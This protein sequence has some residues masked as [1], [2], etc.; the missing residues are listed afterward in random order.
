MPLFVKSRLLLVFT[1]IVTAAMLSACGISLAEDITP[2][3][4]YQ[5]PTASTPQPVDVSTV[6]PLVPPDPAQGAAIYAEK[7]LPCHGETG[8]GDGPQASKLSNP[9]APIGSTELA[10]QRKPAEWF[11]IVTV[12]NLE[13]FMPGFSQSLSD[14]QRWDIVAYVYTL[15]ASADELAQGKEL[16]NTNCAECHGETGLG[17]GAKAASLSTAPTS[18]KEQSELSQLSTNEISDV[19][20]QGAGDMPGFADKLDESQRQAVAAYIRALSFVGQDDNQ[21]ANASATETSATPQATETSDLKKITITGKITNASAGGSVPSNMKVTLVAYQGM[22]PAFELSGEATA[23][24]TYTFSEVEYQADYVYITRV[25]I[26]QMSFNSDILHGSDVTTEQAEL[27]VQIYDV[28]TDAS[29]LRADRLHVFFDFSQPGAVQ[30]VQLYIITNPTE[31]VIAAASPESPVIRFD[32][33]EGAQSLQFEDGTIG[34]RYVETA[35]GFGDTLSVMP[36]QG[37]HQILYAYE[38]PYD[39]KLDLK[40]KAPLPVD[41][42]IIMVPQDGI[43]LKSDQLEDSGE[44]SVQGMSFQMYTNSAALAAG[45]ELSLSL[46]GRANV[47]GGATNENEWLPVA[48]AGAVFLLV[49]AGAA[50]WFLSQR[51]RLKPVME[52]VTVMDVEEEEPLSSDELLDAIVALDDQFQA[53]KLSDTA[54][55]ERRAE[56]KVRLSQ[57]MDQ[58]KNQ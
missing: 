39:R 46:S 29:V 35:T 38:L 40:L 37:Q 12:G 27:P 58:E 32:L 2:P 48:I 47:T 26:D 23:D 50:Y 9:P 43:R 56:L 28:S 33:P 41:A 14:R 53:G 19:I 30:V 21:Q 54:Y 34:D 25:D 44:R 8:M 45:D 49:V 31:K 22:D 13:K 20:A 36:G 11:N 52:G 18:W 57:A 42:A 51:S 4:N 24:G 6:Y 17:D 7:C 15:S 1:V 55:Q 16:Y 3:P 10:R 5:S